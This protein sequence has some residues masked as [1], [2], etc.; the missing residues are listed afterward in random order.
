MYSLIGKLKTLKYYRL[1]Q[2]Q[3][4]STF[5][6]G[7]FTHVIQ[8]LEQQYIRGFEDDQRHVLQ[9]IDETGDLTQYQNNLIMY[10]NQ[11]EDEVPSIILNLV[12]KTAPAATSVENNNN[13]NNPGQ[14]VAIR[15]VLSKD[16]IAR[17]QLCQFLISRS[18]TYEIQD[19][20]DIIASSVDESPET[21]TTTTTTTNSDPSLI[22]QA[23][24]KTNIDVNKTGLFNNPLHIPIQLDTLSSVTVGQIDAIF[25]PFSTQISTLIPLQKSQEYIKQLDHLAQ[26]ASK[27]FHI[28][29][30]QLNNLATFESLPVASNNIIT[31]L[32]TITAENEHEMLLWQY[33]IYISSLYSIVIPITMKLGVHFY[34]PITLY[35]YSLKIQHALNPSTAAPKKPTPAAKDGN[36]LYIEAYASHIMLISILRE[37]SRKLQGEFTTTILALKNFEPTC[38]ENLPPALLNLVLDKGQD[39]DVIKIDEDQTVEI[40]MPSHI[41]PS[42]NANPHDLKAKKKLYDQ[43][44]PPVG[45]NEELKK[46]TQ[47]ALKNEVF[48]NR[49]QKISN[50]VNHRYH[51]E[52]L[53]LIKNITSQDAIELLKTLSTLPIDTDEMNKN[54]DGIAKKAK[55]STLQFT[56]LLATLIRTLYD[57]DLQQ[58]QTVI[59]RWMSYLQTFTSRESPK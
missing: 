59:T 28:T 32:L 11:L 19:K 36:Q 4:S 24:K 47:Q 56:V 41:F 17:I 31:P 46:I 58:K 33:I 48:A 20:Q 5:S 40:T 7:E 1:D 44:T 3:K 27:D 14:V 8:F 30:L 52:K 21:T 6:F 49:N 23:A 34:L 18:I 51:L 53:L 39:Q 55:I 50:F 42:G 9:P 12:K 57:H 54:N 29:Q 2:I 37:F 15:E 26:T 25:Q 45:N 13:N 35:Q 38:A 43:K 16:A 10:L 22:Y